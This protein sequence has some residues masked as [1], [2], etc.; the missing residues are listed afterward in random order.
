M[1]MMH[2][3]RFV[4]C[5][6]CSTLV[7]D[8]DHGGGPVGEWRTEVRRNSQDFPFILAVNLNG[9]KKIKSI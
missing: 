8:D 5:N 7:G 1:I 9:F 4:D 6:K 3:N 2:Q